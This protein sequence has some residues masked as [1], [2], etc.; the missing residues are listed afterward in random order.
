MSILLTS[1]IWGDHSGGFS[2]LQGGNRNVPGYLNFIG[3]G[4]YWWSDTG[5]L[6]SL[7]RQFAI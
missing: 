7:I 1:L 3:S 6:I 4:G 2:E 5:F